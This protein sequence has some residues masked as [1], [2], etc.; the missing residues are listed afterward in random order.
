[1]PDTATIDL[2]GVGPTK[3]TWVYVGSAAVAGILVY[4]Y[5]RRSS[6]PT[7]ADLSALGGEGTVAGGDIPAGT[8]TTPGISYTPATQDPNTLPPA[9]NALWLQRAVEYLTISLAYDPQTTGSALGKYLARQPVT[10]KEA[11]II[12]TAQGAIGRPPEGEFT[13][14]MVSTPPYH[15][16]TGVHTTGPLPAGQ[17]VASLAQ[18][19]WDDASLGWAIYN[20][21]V[22]T[23]ENGAIRA[24]H[25][26][27]ENGKFLAA[28]IDLDIPPK[29]E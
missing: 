2:P 22:S 19:Y 28:G 6:Q 29:P 9:T 23:I 25:A 20:A 11:D 17:S 24:G 14:I 27:S 15:T 10:S 4:A 12:R 26:N 16:P 1:M 13:I 8:S 7:T 21:N 18:N 5:W 3:K